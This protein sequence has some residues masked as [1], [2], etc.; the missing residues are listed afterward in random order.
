ML[1]ILQVVYVIAILSLPQILVAQDDPCIEPRNSYAEDNVV[2]IHWS[3][4]D[5][6]L[7]VS[8]MGKVSVYEMDGDDSQVVIH[9]FCA[10]R[11]PE[12]AVSDSYYAVGSDF[13]P[14]VSV[15]D[16]E[17]NNLVYQLDIDSENVRSISFNQTENLIAVS[18]SNYDEG[19]FFDIDRN[20]EVWDFQNGEV[21]ATLMPEENLDSLYLPFDTDVAFLEENLVLIT[22]VDQ[23][24]AFVSTQ[25]FVMV[26]NWRTGEISDSGIEANTLLQVIDSWR[27]VIIDSDQDS[28]I[29]LQLM[30]L[31]QDFHLEESHIYDIEI[32]DMLMTRFSV[33][34]YD[35]LLAIENAEGHIWI[36]DLAKQKIVLYREFERFAN[37]ISF[38]H[39]GQHLA[40]GYHDGTLEV[41]DIQNDTIA[42]I[43]HV[44]AR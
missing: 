3:P 15:Y 18:K 36:I 26:W 37:S 25:P 35:S 24:D 16:T 17:T 43:G 11:F 29:S 42:L 19:G 22:G 40:L 21:L 14:I 6:E 33:N 41:W 2:D 5:T 10:G 39:A 28:K 34:A 12:I 44:F 32:E 38:D 23:E 7:Y 30:R 4:S 31:Q 27:L 9:E 20:I 1:K 8:T 13:L